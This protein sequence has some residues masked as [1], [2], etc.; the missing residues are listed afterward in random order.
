MVI[1][2]SL[3]IHYNSSVPALGTTPMCF[4]SLLSAIRLYSESF[5]LKPTLS[6]RVAFWDGAPGHTT[7]ELMLAQSAPP[8]QGKQACWLFWTPTEISWTQHET[9]IPVLDFFFLMGRKA[10]SDCL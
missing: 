6:C 3:A 1:V 7:L 4:L 5:P 9:H 2:L 10:V 8:G